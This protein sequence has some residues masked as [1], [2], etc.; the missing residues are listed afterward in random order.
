[1]RS[2]TKCDCKTLARQ[3]V[4]LHLVARHHAPISRTPT[5]IEETQIQKPHPKPIL[6]S[7]SK[8]KCPR[9]ILTPVLMK[10]GFKSFMRNWFSSSSWVSSSRNS[11]SSAHE[12]PCQT[13]VL[14]L[15]QPAHRVLQT[16]LLVIISNRYTTS[17]YK[18]LLF[19]QQI[20]LSALIRHDLYLKPHLPPI[21]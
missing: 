11:G 17:S 3:A 19:V 2:V 14:M 18:N 13:A 21:H 10:Y 20:Q 9:F 6:V 15:R 1:M 4:C 16:S 7:Q 12:S 8:L 5:T